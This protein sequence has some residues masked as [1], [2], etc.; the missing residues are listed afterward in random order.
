MIRGFL[1]RS[2]SREPQGFARGTRRGSVLDDVFKTSLKTR[3]KTRGDGFSAMF[4]LL[5]HHAGELLPRL[6]G[7]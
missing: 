2:R 3:L 1:W 4:V 7:G 5:S 6:V